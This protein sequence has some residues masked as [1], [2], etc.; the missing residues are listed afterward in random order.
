MKE[1]KK[2]MGVREG[3]NKDSG[4]EGVFGYMVVE[5]ME[6]VGVGME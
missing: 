4:V 5:G 1:Y 6:G 3:G 2:G